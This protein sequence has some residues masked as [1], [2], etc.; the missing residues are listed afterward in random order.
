MYIYIYICYDNKV[1]ITQLHIDNF[2]R[3][4]EC[5]IKG[6]EKEKLCIDGYMYDINAQ[7]CDYPSK[8]N[9]TGRPKQRK[10][11]TKCKKTIEN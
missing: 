5:N 8:V 10:F 6:E 4:Y 11:A 3:Y 1:N 9:C 7:H 2:T